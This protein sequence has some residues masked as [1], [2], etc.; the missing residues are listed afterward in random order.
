MTREPP[1]VTSGNGRAFNGGSRAPLYM[2]ISEG[3]FRNPPSALLAEDPAAG[4]QP[5]DQKHQ[6]EQQEQTRQE[7][8]DGDRRAGNRR[9]AEQRRHEPNDE[10]NQSHME[11]AHHLQRQS[12]AKGMPFSVFRLRAFGAS[13]RQAGPW[14]RHFG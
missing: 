5:D 8:R 7:L 10:E 6:E 9:E 2:R 12:V 4:G 1:A 14:A 3:G 11:H 13:A